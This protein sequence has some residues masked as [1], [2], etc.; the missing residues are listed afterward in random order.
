MDIFLKMQALVQSH[1]NLHRIIHTLA[2]H[3][4]QGRYDE[5]ESCYEQV[6][7]LSMQIVDLLIAIE[8]NAAKSIADSI[9]GIY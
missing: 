7:P 4:E 5:A 2:D 8:R 9:I 3:H 6:V 1:E